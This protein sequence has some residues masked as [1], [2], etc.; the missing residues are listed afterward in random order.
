MAE[1]TDVGRNGEELATSY[2][3]NNGYTIRDRNWRWKTDELDLV[4]EL[5][6]FLV[7]VE[8]KTRSTSFF[9]DPAEAVSPSKQQRIIRAT[10]AY[11]DSFELD[12]EV[13]FDVIS[14]VLQSNTPHIKH[15]QD[16]F[17]A[18]W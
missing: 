6:D 2:L 7:V 15:I 4:A 9:G 5:E 8:V 13:R 16:A 3:Q 18:T 10:E 17:Q 12:K 14:I 1:H 11:L